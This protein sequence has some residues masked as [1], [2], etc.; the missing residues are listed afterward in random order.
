VW[1]RL[2][3][4]G[5][6][7]GVRRAEGPTINFLGFKDKVCSGTACVV[8][9]GQDG[10]GIAATGQQHGWGWLWCIDRLFVG[11][12]MR[13]QSS[14]NLLLWQ[15]SAPGLTDGTMPEGVR[16]QLAQILC[17]QCQLRRVTLGC[18]KGFVALRQPL[19]D[20]GGGC[21]G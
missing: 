18:G 7:L 11:Q 2:G 9:R 8:G 12:I 19:Q 6:Q 20:R 4:R 15:N 1:T 16:L 3:S 17:W 14:G 13:L 10:L 21:Q 5:C